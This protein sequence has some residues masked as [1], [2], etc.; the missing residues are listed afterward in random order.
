M[1][2]DLLGSGDPDED[3]EEGMLDADD[4]IMDRIQF[5]LRKQLQGAYDVALLKVSEQNEELTREKRR[6][7]DIGVQLYAVQQQLAKLQMNLEK[8]HENHAIIGQM[9]EGAEDDLLK[10]RAAYEHKYKDAKEHRVKYDQYQGELDQLAMTLRQVEAYNEQMKGE[11]AVTRRATYKAEESINQL[12]GG[13]KVQDNMIDK[14]NENLKRAQ[15]E[16]ALHEAQLMAQRGE[17]GAA[18]QTLRDA[19]Q[20]MD[21]INYEKK[22]LLQQWKSAL[23]GM[24]RRDEALQATEDALRKQREQEEAIEG[25]MLG[26]KKMIKKEQEK[27][28]VL[29]QTVNKLGAEQK[30]VEAG[31]EESKMKEMA[32][33]ERFAMLNK[34]LEQTDAELG[35]VN[36]EH[37][38]LSTEVAAIETQLQKV[39]LEAKQ[40]EDAGVKDLGEQLA[41]EKGTQSLLTVTEKLKLQVQEKEMAGAQLQNELARI[42]VD[43][44]NTKSH[45]TQLEATLKSTN[46]EL[47]EKDALMLKYES[48]AR[49]RNVEIEKKAHELDLLNKKFDGLMKARAGV[50][51]LDED[52]GPLEATI[53][54]LKKEM[55]SVGA[56]CAELQRAWIKQQTE[57]VTVQKDNQQVSEELQDK[58]AQIAIL[59][60]KRVRIDAQDEAV[61]KEIRQLGRLSD[62][63]HIEMAKINRLVSEHGE[64]QQLLA[65]ENFLTETE[66]VQKLKELESGAIETEAKIVAL[67]EE[68]E[69]LLVDTLEA[70]KQTMLLEKKIALERETQAALDPEVGAAEVRAM[71]REIHRMRLRYAQLQ[72]RQET[73]ITDMERAI[74]KRDNIETKGKTMAGK[75]GAPPTGATLQK[76]TAEL[77]KKLKMTTHDANL[78]QMNVLK[79]QEAQRERG[80]EVEAL[81]SEVGELRLQTDRV[82]STI[83]AQV[84]QQLA[85]KQ[86]LARNHRLAQTLMAAAE[87]QYEP[88]MDPDTVREEMED[89]EI[90]NQRLL[91]IID[92]LGQ[93]QPQYAAQLSVLAQTVTA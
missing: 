48:E 31:L 72:K 79:L 45:N 30:V 46:A 89:A 78:T 71:Q 15:E 14:L 25:E 32:H 36:Q 37:T 35:K 84:Q 73:M 40:V 82:G 33:H 43:T 42:R 53:L 88:Q 17:S 91:G 59:E 81:S 22:Q 76:Q 75:K 60:Q 16:L 28:E 11:I 93:E 57:L 92:V 4:P 85:Q 19:Q 24:Q 29:T 77:S 63:M 64:K 86:L 44:L 70:E 51:D 13:K 68:K 83:G 20:E 90:T 41:T 3:E 61:Q 7:E 23:L 52:A 66:F 12:E 56:E 10:V 49:R 87:G 58:R 18:D 8:V 1:P 55:A 9:R 27:N 47:A 2:E 38:T 5:A 62:N 54:H 69:G 50:D 39:L 21:A 65:D 74:Y 80:G 26:L 67:K 34:S 6:R